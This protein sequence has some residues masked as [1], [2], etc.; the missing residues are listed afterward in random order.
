LTKNVTQHIL[1]VRLQIEFLIKSQQ[2][3]YDII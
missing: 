2:I 3:F 1:T